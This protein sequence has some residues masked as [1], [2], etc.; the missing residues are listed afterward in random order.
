MFSNNMLEA[1]GLHVWSNAD[2]HYYPEFVNKNII[3][4]TFLK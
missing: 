2:A 3:K 4:M 1:L